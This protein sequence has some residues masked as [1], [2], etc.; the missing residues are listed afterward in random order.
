MGA[1]TKAVHEAEQKLGSNAVDLGS[2]PLASSGVPVPE[3]YQAYLDLGR[4][5][6][7]LVL[8]EEKRRPTAALREFVQNWDLGAYEIPTH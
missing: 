8:D 3:I 6:N 2:V 5:R 4:F 1:F 7:A